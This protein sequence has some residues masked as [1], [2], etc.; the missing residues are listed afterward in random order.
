M[1]NESRGAKLLKVKGDI[2]KEEKWLRN[3]KE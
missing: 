1:R 2:N 3:A